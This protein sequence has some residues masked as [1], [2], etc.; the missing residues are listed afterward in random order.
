M[1]DRLGKEFK[2]GDMVVYSDGRYADLYIGH[3]IGMTP[4]MIRIQNPRG[5]R[6]L[7]APT[8]VAIVEAKD[9]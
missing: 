5:G 2:L 8:Q 6:T 3:V 7:K 4:K 1:K 9:A